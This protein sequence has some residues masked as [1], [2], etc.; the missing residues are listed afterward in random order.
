MPFQD[1]YTLLN[2]VAE[3]RVISS[4]TEFS[5][6][7]QLTNFLSRLTRKAGWKY[8]RIDTTDQQG[9]PDILLLKR[10]TYWQ[11]EA[12]LLKK[13]RLVSLENDLRYEF[14]Q[15]AYMKRAFTLGLNY[16]LVVSK[17]SKIAFIKGIPPNETQC[18]DY[19]D[20]IR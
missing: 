15:V 3:C 10:D 20:F 17:G 1:Q 19:P 4:A 16:M 18:S 9:F 14:G 7:K 5:L 6:E 8:L 2:S 11:I 13:K 12:K